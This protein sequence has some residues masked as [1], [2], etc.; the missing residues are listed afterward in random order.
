MIEFIVS[1][2]GCG[3][4][5]KGTSSSKAFRCSGCNQA[6]TFPS[7]AR[8]P[9][10][11]YVFCS[12]CWTEN[13]TQ[14]A[15]FPC[16]QC[17]QTLNPQCVGRAVAW[18]AG[19]SLTPSVL[20]GA[21]DPVER[22]RGDLLT[23]IKDLESKLKKTESRTQDLQVERDRAIA[24]I[25]QKQM[26]VVQLRTEF[27]QYRN[28]AVQAL[29]PI[30]EEFAKRMR[31]LLDRLDQAG[32]DAQTLREEFV[33]RIEKLESDINSAREQAR[34]TTN[35]VNTRL[36][37]VLGTP[38]AKIEEPP[39]ARPVVELPKGD[40]TMT[41]AMNDILAANGFAR[42]TPLTPIKRPGSHKKI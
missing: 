27:Q 21:D 28:I 18:A 37:S 25:N 42:S 30:G 2:S 33:V 19:S 12:N 22:D 14:S 15:P 32:K 31:K 3:K 6:F 4:R 20:D 35:E 10:S 39:P 36:S 5:Y 1:C 16:A 8:T 24:Q 23:R 17:Q 9:S 26:E 41:Q 7:A 29:E 13:E 11:G 38:C 40:L 34:N